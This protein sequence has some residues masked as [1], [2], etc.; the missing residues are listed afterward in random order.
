MDC[1]SDRGRAFLLAGRQNFQ[2]G[3]EKRKDILGLH[4]NRHPGCCDIGTKQYRPLF[5]IH[6][7]FLDAFWQCVSNGALSRQLH[8]A[9]V[10]YSALYLVFL[11]HRYA[12]IK[13]V[14]VCRKPLQYKR[15]YDHDILPAENRTGRSGKVC[16]DCVYSFNEKVAD[17]GHKKRL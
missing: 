2:E 12:G 16:H 14:F 13:S 4:L 6:A 17:S 10:T 15:R 9:F 8:K 3:A 11:L 5:L 7:L 1:L